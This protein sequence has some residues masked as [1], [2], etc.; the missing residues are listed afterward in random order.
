MSSKAGAR[1]KEA[2]EGLYIGAT[3]TIRMQLWVKDAPL[4]CEVWYSPN[5][6]YRLEAKGV[7]LEGND[8]H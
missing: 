6:Y 2:F 1:G 5:N 7:S 3:V 8:F 4:E